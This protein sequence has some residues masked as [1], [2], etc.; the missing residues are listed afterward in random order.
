M[1]GVKHA[2]GCLEPIFR[3]GNVIEDADPHPGDD[4]RCDEARHGESLAPAD[5]K[6]AKEVL[7]VERD[8]QLELLNSDIAAANNLQRRFWSRNSDIYRLDLSNGDR[9]LIKKI[10]PDPVGLI[11]LEVKPGGVQIAHDGKS[12]VYTYW[13][14][15]SDLFLLEGLK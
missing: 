1:A 9:K 14:Y 7:L 11:G 3:P 12:Y 15:L 4:Q 13:T 5:F 10:V 2:C 6:A 8:G